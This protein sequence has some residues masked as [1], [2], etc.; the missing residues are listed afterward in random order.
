MWWD[1]RAII[2]TNRSLNLDWTWI[3]AQLQ[4]AVFVSD[5]V[6][7][8]AAVMATSWPEVI[9]QSELLPGSS[10]FRFGSGSF[11][12]AATWTF[13]LNRR[14]DDMRISV[15]R[16]LSV[17]TQLSGPQWTWHASCFTPRALNQTTT[18]CW[19]VFSSGAR[20][21]QTCGFTSEVT[22]TRVASSAQAQKAKHKVNWKQ[23]KDAVMKN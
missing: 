7:V 12:S 16:E 14:N 20:W 22:E 1:C 6:W 23:V 2:K 9:S 4:F 11:W 5:C 10:Q 13:N 18:T 8:T 3:P 19:A 17:D 15:Q 21:I